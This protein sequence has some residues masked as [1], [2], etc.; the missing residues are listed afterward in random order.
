MLKVE[1]IVV[2]NFINITLPGLHMN[3]SHIKKF[4]ERLGYI[5]FIFSF[6]ALAGVCVKLFQL[7]A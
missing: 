3:I 7:L 2:K 6:W 1:V 5:L 4:G